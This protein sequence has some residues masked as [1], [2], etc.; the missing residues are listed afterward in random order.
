MSLD[1]ATQDRMLR[2]IP[3]LRAFARSLCRNRDHADDLVQETLLRAIDRISTFEKGSNLEAWLF[4]IMRNRFNSDYRTSKRMVQDTDNRLAETLAVPPAQ[5]GWIVARDLRAGLGKL[6]V[7]QQQALFLVGASALS[8][9]E[10][11]AIAGCHVGTMKSRV[12][13]ARTTLAA[14]MSDEEASQAERMAS[15]RSRGR[16]A[17]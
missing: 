2:A 9:D 1:A 6:P 7:P 13:R 15:A 8:Y 5:T 16:R 10:A 3:S 4:T 17:A 14:F 11:A 12:N